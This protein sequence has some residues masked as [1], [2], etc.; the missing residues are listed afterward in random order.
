MALIKGKQAQR[1]KGKNGFGN[2]WG[3]KT[4]AGKCQVGEWRANGMGVKSGVIELFPGKK[5]V[6][7]LVWHYA[8]SFL[9]S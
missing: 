6:Q 7:S 3:K 4:Y 9:T 2:T 8:H 5:E 1:E